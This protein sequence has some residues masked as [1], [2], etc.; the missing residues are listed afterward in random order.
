MWECSGSTLK[1]WSPGVSR[2]RQRSP[3]SKSGY[4]L[5][6]CLSSEPKAWVTQLWL[7]LNYPYT[8]NAPQLRREVESLHISWLFCARLPAQA[9]DGPYS[10]QKQECDWGRWLI[11]WRGNFCIFASIQ[12]WLLWSTLLWAATKIKAV[13]DPNFHANL[14]NAKTS[15]EPFAPALYTIT[16]FILN[17]WLICYKHQWEE[18][19]CD[20]FHPITYHLSQEFTSNA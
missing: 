18:I 5:F 7:L 1:I 17:C 2:R 4:H 12:R 11:W 3:A 10:D 13:T 9:T 15:W 20:V 16:A 19:R 8:N 14:A 6:F